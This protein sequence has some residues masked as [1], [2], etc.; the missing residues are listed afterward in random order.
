MSGPGSFAAAALRFAIAAV[1]LATSVGKLL[2]LPG[3][4]RVLE[5]H[6]AFPPWALTPVAV[7]VPL[8]EL[9]LGLWLI[10]GRRLAAAAVASGS[11]HLLY[12][13]WAAAH[14]LRGLDIP[15]CG[16]FG[17]FLARPLTWRTVVEDLVLVALSALLAILA[18][19]AA[20]Q[21]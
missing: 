21:A 13:A 15:N 11:L 17:V 3:F 8:T 4:T 19:Q 2:D 1:L 12:G 18:G 10:S 6:R 7:A 14:V 20:R 16:C 9:A 5:T